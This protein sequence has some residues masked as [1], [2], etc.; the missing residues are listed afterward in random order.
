MIQNLF[1]EGKEENLFTSL[2]Q[3]E[4]DFKALYLPFILF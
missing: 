4:F 1:Y 2:L 3:H